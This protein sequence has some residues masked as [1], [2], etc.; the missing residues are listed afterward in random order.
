MFAAME[1]CY[2][3]RPNYKFDQKDSMLR[4][5][6]QKKLSESL[7][8]SIGKVGLET[9]K[10]FVSFCEK[11]K[12]LMD[13]DENYNKVVNR[14]MKYVILYGVLFKNLHQEIQQMSRREMLDVIKKLVNIFGMPSIDIL[15]EELEPLSKKYGYV[16]RASHVENFC[17]EI[18]KK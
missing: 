3:N 13:R 11:I 1:I 8:G 7:D 10:K 2:L 18:E 14:T 17:Q 12:P 6:S 5:N 16:F 4:S 15:I 9:L